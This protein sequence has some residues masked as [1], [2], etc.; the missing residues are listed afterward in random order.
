MSI[1]DKELL[2]NTNLFIK[3]QERVCIMGN[4]GTGKSTLIKR[5]INKDENIKIGSNVKIGYVP[6]DIVFEDETLTVLQE[7]NKYFIGTEEILR[8]ALTKFLFYSEGVFTRLSKLSGGERLR[9]K[10]FCLMQQDNNLLI[11]DEPTN[12]IDINTKE[13]LEEALLSYKGTIIMISHDRYFIN[14]VA[15]RIIR[16]EDKKLISYVGNYDD[17]K[18][19]IARQNR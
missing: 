5:I 18:N 3:Y 15:T 2:K 17:Y 7:A 12:H 11:L 6:Q 1:G 9:L 14:K 19:T 13:V 8:S 4:N 10:L 16:I